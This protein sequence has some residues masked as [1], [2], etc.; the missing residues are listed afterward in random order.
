MPPASVPAQSVL[1]STPC[2]RDCWR[3]LPLALALVG[4]SSAVLAAHPLQ[5]EDT[6]T[7]GAGNVELENGS[8]FQRTREGHVAMYQ[9]QASL[10]ATADLDLIVQPAWLRQRTSDGATASGPGDTNV[11]AKWR[12]FGASPL[13][14]AIRAGGTVTTASRGLGIGGHRPA[15]HAVLVATLDLA[16]LSLHVNVGDTRE[17]SGTG[18][19]GHVP[20]VSSA[21]LYALD[22]R[23]MLCG[24]LAASRDPDP[25]VVPWSASV[26]AG[27]I[28]TLRPGLDLDAGWQS[29]VWASSAAPHSRQWLV[30]LTWRFAP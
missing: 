4:G 14:L 8:T 26:L 12:Y 7:Q 11:D 16:P 1:P 5:T 28:R 21:A 13:T 15:L 10:G 6:G 2:R 22:E 27:V 18:L 17:P 19:R 29:N 3:R 30:G 24:E 9:L 20:F 23:W 25:R